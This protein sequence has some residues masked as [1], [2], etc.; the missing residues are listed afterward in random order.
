MAGDN[1][2]WED[3]F[4][5]TGETKLSEYI[6]TCKE[7]R[8]A[9]VKVLSK[10]QT[11][12]AAAQTS[13]FIYIVRF[14]HIQKVSIFCQNV[15]TFLPRVSEV[16]GRKNILC[17][18]WMVK[19]VLGAYITPVKLVTKLVNFLKGENLLNF[20]RSFVASLKVLVFKTTSNFGGDDDGT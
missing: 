18:F 2:L 20:W 17:K 11:I 16:L 7:G 15:M 9:E 6:I 19:S 10:G 13:I 3:Q 5:L 1:R 14:F 12:S 8:W 4:N